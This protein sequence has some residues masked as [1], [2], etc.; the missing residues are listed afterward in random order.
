MYQDKEWIIEYKYRWSS[1]SGAD[2]YYVRNKGEWKHESTIWT[3]SYR[4][5][6][7]EARGG[8]KRSKDSYGGSHDVEILGIYE[9]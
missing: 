4:P 2:G 6:Y 7:E 1:V 9:R 8:V 3:V 5:T